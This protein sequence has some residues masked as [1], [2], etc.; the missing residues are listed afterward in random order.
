[1][2][3]VGGKRSFP[4]DKPAKFPRGAAGRSFCRSLA[5]A[6]DDDEYGC[7]PCLSGR[8]IIDRC[9]AR[10]Y[11]DFLA[12]GNHLWGGITSQCLFA[13]FQSRASRA[14]RDIV[15]ES[16]QARA[17][18][19]LQ[20]TVSLAV[21]F[22]PVLAAMLYNVVGVYLALFVNAL[23]F[24]GSFLAILAIRVPAEKERREQAQGM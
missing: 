6:A 2:G 8:C 22:G 14:D 5:E 24:V 12:T 16:E 7:D 1:M 13:V 17:T 21:I 15:P 23:S 3:A 18:G 4:D 19:M 10:A 20:M 11:N 9:A